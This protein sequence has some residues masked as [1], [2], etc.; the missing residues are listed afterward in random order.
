[1]AD[2]EQVRSGGRLSDG[3]RYR[4]AGPTRAVAACRCRRSHSSGR[5]VTATST[6]GGSV[7]IAGQEPWSRSSDVARRGFV[8]TCGSSQ[9]RGGPGANLSIHRSA[10]G[11]AAGLSPVGQIH[12]ADKGNH[13]EVAAGPA[14]GRRADPVLT[15]R[16]P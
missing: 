7:A 1:M 13:N 9:F 8:L 4:V 11:A 3:V 12:S 6:R 2:T 14:A 15:T 5:F 16:V 10:L